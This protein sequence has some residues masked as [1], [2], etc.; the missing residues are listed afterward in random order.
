MIPLKCFISGSTGFVGAHLVRHFAL[1]GAS[2]DTIGRGGAPPGLQKFA[3]YCAADIRTDIPV[4]DCAIAVHAAGLAS[5]NMTL[6][7]LRAAN[8]MGTQKIFMATQSANIFI[9]ISSSSVYDYR[10]TC[11]TEEDPVDMAL[12]S[13]YGRSKREAENWLLS[14][15]WRERTLVILRPRAIY[16]TGDRMLLPRLL[17]LTR[18][19]KIYM[20]GEAQPNSSLTH[21]NNLCEAV[22]GSLLLPSGV[23]V[24]NVADAFPYDLRSAIAALLSEVLDKKMCLH[25]I[26]LKPLQWIAR[27]NDQLHLGLPI[28][29]MAL[30]SLIKDSV[31]NIHK[32]SLKLN[33]TPL[34]SFETALSEIG[35]W[36][37]EV[38]LSRLR[39]GHPG[40]PWMGY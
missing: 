28:T 23:H 11:H 36:A 14:Q 5:D 1:R 17:R 16:G 21:I 24:F 18:D 4:Q 30:N 10:S 26:P 7:A 31:L 39:E 13:P 32:I 8:V 15:D 37:R 40:L 20:P 25:S 6:K 3:R 33:F 29:N 9:Y 12:L 35:N 2:V 19:N 38:G 27:W 34:F 22:Q